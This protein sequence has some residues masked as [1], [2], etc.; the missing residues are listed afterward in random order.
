MIL[1]DREKVTETQDWHTVE[2]DIRKVLAHPPALPFTKRLLIQIIPLPR[3]ID[4]LITQF[5]AAIN[6]F[7]ADVNIIW[8]LVDLN[9]KAR[10]HGIFPGYY[11]C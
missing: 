5:T 8:G 1:P 2:S 11:P 10:G 9:I 4:T 6:P 7:N 3:T